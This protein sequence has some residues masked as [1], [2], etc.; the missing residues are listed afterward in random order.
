[1]LLIPHGLGWALKDPEVPTCPTESQRRTNEV[2]RSPVDQHRA[3]EYQQQCHVPSAVFRVGSYFHTE[4]SSHI[5]LFLSKNIPNSCESYTTV[6][7]L[8]FAHPQ[9]D[10][11]A[12][13][14]SIACI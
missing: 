10:A 5:R 3:E 12:S 7:G 14:D 4:D 2:P 11:I 13:G 8:I 1:M 9:D 6:L